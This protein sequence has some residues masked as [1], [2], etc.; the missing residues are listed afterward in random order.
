MESGKRVTTS[1]PNSAKRLL[2]KTARFLL[3]A[4][5]IACATLIVT[6]VCAAPVTN[7]HTFR[8]ATPTTLSGQGTSSPVFG[9]SSA[10]ATAAFLIG[11]FDAL[12]LTN[13]GD[14]ITLTF[15][16]SFTDAGG[17]NSNDDQ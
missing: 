17:M 5:S 3:I 1:H 2:M 12:S 6:N 9:S 8:D 10:T 16:V 11:Y 4:G 7:W 15:Q 13:A 14:R